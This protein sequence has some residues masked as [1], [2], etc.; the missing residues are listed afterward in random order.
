MVAFGWE[1]LTEEDAGC[2]TEEHKAVKACWQQAVETAEEA[3]D[4]GLRFSG[5]KSACGA[6][7]LTERG[8]DRGSSS[9][10]WGC[11]WP[12]SVKWSHTRGWQLLSSW[13]VDEKIGGGILVEESVGM[14]RHL[15]RRSR[16]LL[17]ER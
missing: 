11:R 17:G 8:R 14:T 6:R 7:W 16:G 12:D 9:L 1:T 2:S 10:C 3:A 13:P 15:R 5:S 4:V